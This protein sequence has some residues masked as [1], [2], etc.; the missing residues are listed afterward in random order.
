MHLF[1]KWEV[2]VFLKKEMCSQ[3]LQE[4][5]FDATD[6]RENPFL[7]ISL[8]DALLLLLNCCSI[9]HNKECVCVNIFNIVFCS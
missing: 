4:F 1:G 9:F 3:E 6:E 7:T 2:V 5:I 8:M